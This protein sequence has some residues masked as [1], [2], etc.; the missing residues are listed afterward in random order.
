MEAMFVSE[1]ESVSR[2]DA[3]GH[4]PFPELMPPRIRQR[5]ISPADLPNELARIAALD[6]EGLRLLWRGLTSTLPSRQLNG[7][8]LK[9]MVMH[10]VQE[11]C[12]GALDRKI[13]KTL[14]RMAE[15]DA[16]SPRRLKLGCVL[17][18]EH[19]GVVHQVTVV[20]NGFAWADQV[21]P[22]LSAAA[23]AITG[24]K[25]NGH[26]FFGLRSAKANDR[27]VEAQQ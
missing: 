7:D 16:P 25:W 27:L 8:L 23:Y 21:L 5:P 3:S 1:L 18:R 22:S 10:R 19:D 15:R 24:T 26:R 17:V 12:L 4:V 6:T 14:D 11:R 13:A 20:A 2:C 9:R